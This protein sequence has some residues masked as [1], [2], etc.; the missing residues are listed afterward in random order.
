MNVLARAAML[1]LGLPFALGGFGLI[2]GFGVFAVIGM[3]LMIVGLG[4]IS[5]AVNTDP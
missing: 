4:L 3:P 1:F 5:A 2:A